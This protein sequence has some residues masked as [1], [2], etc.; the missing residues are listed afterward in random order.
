M[1]KEEITEIA[2]G[3]ID[4]RI[5][6]IADLQANY[7]LQNLGHWGD[8]GWDIRIEELEELKLRVL[9]RIDTK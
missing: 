5:K 7:R 2:I 3:A 8:I 6:E 9:E 4:A 1:T